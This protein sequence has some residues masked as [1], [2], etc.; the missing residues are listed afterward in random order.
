FGTIFGTLSSA[1]ILG[2]ASGLWVAGLVFD[3]AGSY[4]PAFWLAIALCLDRLHLAGR[5][6][7]VG[8][9]AGRVARSETLGAGASEPRS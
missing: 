4:A 9:V 2:A 3:R 1:S 7:K 6:P 8:L 5:P